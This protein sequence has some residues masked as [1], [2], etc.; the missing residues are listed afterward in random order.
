MSVAIMFHHVTGMEALETGVEA[1]W[2][3]ITARDGDYVAVFMPIHAARAVAEAFNKAMA[4]AQPAA[5]AA[6]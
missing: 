3:R 2:L 5:H 1:E 6:E 4:E